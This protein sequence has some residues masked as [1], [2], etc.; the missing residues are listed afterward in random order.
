MRRSRADE[1]AARARAEEARA[2]KSFTSP[3]K[4]TQR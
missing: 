2:L 1:E 4:R 3:L